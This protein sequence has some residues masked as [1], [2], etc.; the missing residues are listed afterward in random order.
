MESDHLI[1]AQH[2]VKTF[3]IGGQRFT[4][5]NDVNL[6]FGRGEFAGIIGQAVRV[7]PLF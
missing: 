2:L 4:A 7:K 3:P 5:L 1:E 6:S